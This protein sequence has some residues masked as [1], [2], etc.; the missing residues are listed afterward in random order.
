MDGLFWPRARPRVAVIGAGIAGLSAAWLLREACDV[1]LFEAERRLGGHA[2]TQEVE[3]AGQ[4]VAVDTGFI[5]YN[6][7]NYPNLVG[8]FDALGVAT[9]SSDMSFG[10]SIGDGRL[11]YAGGAW[12][13]LRNG[14][15]PAPVHNQ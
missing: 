11:E 4:R 5:V 12:T 7:A 1:T 9:E 10:V 14:I 15:A 3:V 6:E 2:D 8:L 13:Q